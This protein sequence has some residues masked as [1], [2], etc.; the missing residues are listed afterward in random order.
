MEKPGARDDGPG[1]TIPGPCYKTFRW[2]GFEK[3]VGTQ[4]VWEGGSKKGGKKGREGKGGE[5]ERRE[6]KEYDDGKGGGAHHCSKQ[7]DAHP[8]PL[9]P[10]F[11]LFFSALPALPHL[12]AAKVHLKI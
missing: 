8:I 3:T 9:L 6:E 11:C 1:G 4:L 10:F 12:E 7:T 2:T 5:D